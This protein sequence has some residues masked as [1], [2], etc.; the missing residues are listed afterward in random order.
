MEGLRKELPEK[1]RGGEKKKHH[2]RTRE[3]KEEIETGIWVD[4]SGTE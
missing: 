1:E 2:K 3:K 4:Y